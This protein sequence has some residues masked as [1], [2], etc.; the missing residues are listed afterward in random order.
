M[1]L[2]EKT[3]KFMATLLAVSRRFDRRSCERVRPGQKKV[4]YLLHVAK[5]EVTL[6]IILYIISAYAAPE[7]QDPQA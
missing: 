5:D 3:A 6:V 7:A 1:T 4:G 2:I